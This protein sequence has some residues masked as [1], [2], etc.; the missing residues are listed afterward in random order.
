[1]ATGIVKWF[2]AEKGYG[3]ISPDDNSAD[4]FVHFS[5][6]EGS[7]FEELCKRTRRWSLRPSRARRA[8]RLLQSARSDLIRRFKRPL[9]PE[10]GRLF[11]VPGPTSV[12]P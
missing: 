3:F 1:M 12:N 7:G 4:I 2:N 9:S 10:E 6:I 8:C 5:A 11:V